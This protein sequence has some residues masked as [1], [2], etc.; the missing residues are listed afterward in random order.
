VSGGFEKIG[1]FFQ[2][3]HMN[4]WLSFRRSS[5]FL[6]DVESAF[7]V[8]SNL[9]F[10]QGTLQKEFVVLDEYFERLKMRKSSQGY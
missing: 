8:C 3:C 6:G 2:I 1:K 5:Q 9:Q 4:R 10:S 7:S